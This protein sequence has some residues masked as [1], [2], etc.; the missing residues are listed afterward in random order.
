MTGSTFISARLE[1]PA[2][3][4]SLVLVLLIAASYPEVVL[5]IS[6]FFFRDFGYFGFPLARYLEQHLLSGQLPLW[7]PL[8]NCGVPFL[9]QWNTMVLYPGSWLVALVGADRG[10]GWFCLA[11]QA[12]GGLGMFLLARH[13]SGSL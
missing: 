3:R 5:G 13:Y 11:H 2:W 12:W 6:A 4:F 9:A 1:S 10:L 7:N 8:S